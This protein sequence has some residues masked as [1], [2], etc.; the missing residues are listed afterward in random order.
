MLLRIPINEGF[1]GNTHSISSLLSHA[2]FTPPRMADMQAEPACRRAVAE[3]WSE[4]E[5]L[6]DH[7]HA[8]RCRGACQEAIGRGGPLH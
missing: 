2:R 1:P 6:L 8:V 4:G 3:G 5:G 7:V